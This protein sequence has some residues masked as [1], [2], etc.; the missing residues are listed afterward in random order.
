M[1]VG[2]LLAGRASAFPPEDPY[3]FLSR[4][5]SFFAER[6]RG[7]LDASAI[8]EETGRPRLRLSLHPAAEDVAI[9]AAGE[10]RVVV[11]AKTASIGPGY[12]RYLCDLMRA[13]GESA[14]IEW[15]PW[16][17]EHHV[18][19]PTGY[20]DGGPAEAIEREMLVWLRE[21]ASQV[22]ALAAS[23]A[24]GLGL[25][26]PKGYE[27][28]AAGD[29]ATPLGPRDAAWIAA[30]A[31]DPIMGADVFPWWDEGLGARV[32][33]SRA[34]CRVW[35]HVRWRPPILESERAVLRAVATDLESAWRE[36]PALA[37]PWLEWQEVLGYLGVGGTIADEVHRRVESAR[38]AP[39]LGYR[40][41]EVRVSLTGGWT[42]R[43]PGS[44]AEGLD[45]DGTWHG[46]DYRRHVVFRSIGASGADAA[47]PQPEALLDGTAREND[48][49]LELSGGPVR[50]RATIAARADGGGGGELTSLCA[51]PGRVAIVTIGFTDSEDR[52]WAIET[53]RSIDHP[54]S[55]GPP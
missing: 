52:D 19:D 26:M 2:L 5:A 28:D 6:C 55:S 3:A 11:A 18:G 22:R 12:H 13:F 23:G 24:T 25:S 45:N 36:D 7:V 44:L 10:G 21:A 17:D 51:V 20:F 43:V 4:A 14:G 16:D 34:L 39:A 40:R 8:D 47:M 32:R 49:S 38:R 50:G 31:A 37:Y 27:F 41:G 53:W 35:T 1:D 30:T 54:A 29:L 46:W 15:A 9:V 33:L 48:A 42:I